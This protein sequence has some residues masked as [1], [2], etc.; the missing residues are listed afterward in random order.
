M[1]VFLV[2][3]GGRDAGDPRS[4]Q[5]K[6]AGSSMY[7][8]YRGPSPYPNLGERVV[9]GK[10]LIQS[11]AQIFAG[12]TSLA[13]N[14]DYVQQLRDMKVIPRGELVAP[15]LAPCAIGCGKALARVHAGTGNP[16]A[17]P[18]YIGQG[19]RFDQ[20]LREFAVSYLDQTAQEQSADPIASG[21]V[22]GTNGQ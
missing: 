21:A 2:L 20:A 5:I 16:V 9:V 19:R 14:D 10:R 15:G 7:E 11:A 1:R 17:I 3:L 13:G 18:A 12:F 4:L 6:R 8:A 22:E